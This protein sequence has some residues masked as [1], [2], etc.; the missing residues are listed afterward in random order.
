MLLSTDRRFSVWEPRLLVV[1][2][3]CTRLTRQFHAVTCWKSRIF[4][5]MVSRTWQDSASPPPPEC[6]VMISVCGCVVRALKKPRLLYGDSL[7]RLNST[8]NAQFQAAGRQRERRRDVVFEWRFNQAPVW[9]GLMA[10]VLCPC[11]ISPPA[12]QIRALSKPTKSLP[13][14]LRNS[15]SRMQSCAVSSAL[16]SRESFGESAL[17]RLR[18]VGC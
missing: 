8:C 2:A 7:A 9:V 16:P 15:K 6:D 18:V 5:C 10:M 17:R 12:K 4:C 1:C 14:Q 11:A 3:R 13:Q